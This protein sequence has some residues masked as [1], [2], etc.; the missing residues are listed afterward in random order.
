MQKRAVIIGGGFAGSAVARKLEDDFNVTLIDAKDYFEFTPSV[1]RTLVEPHH[2]K[3]IQVLHRNYLNRAVVVKGNVKEVNKK[4]AVVSK[5]KFPYDYLVICSGSEYNL[6]M[7]DKS[8]VT[9][10][11]AQVLIK[12]ASKLKKS[13]SVLIIGGGLVGVE[14][15]AEIIGKY[16]DKKITIIHSKDALIE[17]NPKKARDYAYKFLK[18]RNVDIKFSE[19]FLGTARNGVYKTDKGSKI[20]SDLVFLCT[21][22]KPNYRCMGKN[23]SYCLNERKAVIVNEYLQVKGFQNVFAAGDITNVREEKTAQNAEKQ[24]EVVIKNIINIEKGKAL[25]KY[26]SRP[27]IMV[28]SLG[29]WHG[30]LVYKNFVL[31][32]LI[33]G[34]LKSLIEWKEMMKYKMSEIF[35]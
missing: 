24:A 25:E 3:K 6:P 13:K 34:I 14:L 5:N 10:A 8:T 27:R 1:L 9:A 20:K 19:I 33:P 29:K 4:Y 23:L 26:L 18:N 17:R 11:R 35:H 22:I 31:T 7:K 30:I 21:G 32:G 28:I 16:P 12:Y 2:I 15:A